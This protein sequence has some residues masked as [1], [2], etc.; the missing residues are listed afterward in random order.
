MSRRE[1]TFCLSFFF[2]VFYETT[3]KRNLTNPVDV[4]LSCT[5]QTTIGIDVVPLVFTT[6]QTL[7]EFVKLILWSNEIRIFIDKRST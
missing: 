4:I 3:V 2:Q 6:S 7:T 5:S 1:R